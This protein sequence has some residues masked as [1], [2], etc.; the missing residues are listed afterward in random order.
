M[1]SEAQAP[2]PSAIKYRLG[3][4]GAWTLFLIALGLFALAAV[5]EVANWRDGARLSRLETIDRLIGK[6]YTGAVVSL[7]GAAAEKSEHIGE[8]RAHIGE[9]S[10]DLDLPSATAQTILVSTAENR[11]WLRRGGKTVFEAVVSTGKGTTLEVEGRKLIFDTPTGRFHIKSKEEN[12]V[13]VPPDWHYVEE[14][15]KKKLDL[16]RPKPGD[17]IDADTGQ[18][19]SKESEGVW[20]ALGDEE[21]R[22]KRVLEVRKDSIVEVSADGT[23]REVEPK[24]FIRTGKALVV[25]PLGFKQR[26]LEKTLGH[27]RLNIGDGYALHGTLAGNQ[28]GRSVSHGCVRL[29]DA[30]IEKLF[31][32]SQVGDEVIIY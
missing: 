6:R 4:L 30:D 17:V 5:A 7:R 2:A 20:S 28:L 8:L 11:L 26:R 24:E 1:S 21:R 16:V 31:Q 27:Y 22:P 18:P 29:G 3:F 23:E 9:A 13:W 15:R 32:M 19:I 25:P 10:V 14:A 12:P